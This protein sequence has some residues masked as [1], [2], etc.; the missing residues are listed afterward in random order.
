VLGSARFGTVV[1]ADVQACGK[2][3]TDPVSALRRRYASFLADLRSS[4][5]AK[6]AGLAGAMIANNLIALVST[7]V[8]AHLLNDY[9]ALAALVSYF[10]ILSVAGLA[11]QV[12]TAREGVL[13]HL[14]VG[15]ALLATLRKWAW[16]MLW[17]TV[18]VTV[19][20]VL[21]RDPIALAVGVPHYPWAAAVGL[22]AGCLYIE[23]SFLR[24]AL[25]GV[26][27]YN[28]VGI[29]LV[30]EQSV[31][32]LIGAT[33]AAVGLGVSGAYL[34]T[35]ISFLA[36]G[37]FCAVRLRRVVA[38]TAPTGTAAGSPPPP[39]ALS[40]WAHVKGAWAPIVGLIVL[41]VLQNI[42]LIAAK[43]R[44]AGIPNLANSYA[45]TAV[46]AKVMVWIAIGAGFYL[47]PEVARRRAQGVD[48]RSVLMRALAIVLVCAVPVLLIFAFGGAELLRIVFKPD[49]LK[50][51]DALLLLSVAFT[52]LA[53]T[54]LATQYML[55]LKRTWFLLPLALVAIAEPV[56]LLRAPDNPRGFAAVVLGVQVVAAAIAFGMAL[57]PDGARPVP[58]AVAVADPA[59]SPEPAEPV[60]V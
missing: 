35:P 26:G 11:L 52:V 37:V 14:G 43:H 48:T 27:D 40:L 1:G 54:Y 4:E 29:S 34:G 6:A 8:F 18:G 9:S 47:V 51:T 58:L 2:K 28:D 45:A 44:F 15:D 41:A 55:A 32:L 33:L 59:E 38:Q 39:A 24:G 23:L 5:T 21:L 12:A 30:A 60:R 22:P 46:A 36:V 17:F 56:L 16:S 42:D 19:V 53:C 49:Q 31:R 57:R 20:S 7:I 3:A 13:G 50:A 25:Q 10:L